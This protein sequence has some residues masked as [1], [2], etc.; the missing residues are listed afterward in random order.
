MKLTQ[1]SGVETVEGKE[2]MVRERCQMGPVA[3]ADDDNQG[4]ARWPLGRSPPR[5]GQTL[6]ELKFMALSS[7]IGSAFGVKLKSQFQAAIMNK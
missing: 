2:F 4:L 7:R 6:M 1:H 3:Q 5:P